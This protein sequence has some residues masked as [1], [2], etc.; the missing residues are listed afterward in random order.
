LHDRR[1]VF[2]RTGVPVNGNQLLNF[3]NVHRTLDKKRPDAF[4]FATLPFV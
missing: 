2:A 4:Y 1:H 3:Y